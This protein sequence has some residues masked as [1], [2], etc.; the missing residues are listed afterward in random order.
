[1]RID[2][3]DGVTR[4]GR[5]E[6]TGPGP[7]ER[8]EG[9]ERPGDR[10]ELSDRAREVAAL[11]A[12]SGALADVRR[13]KVEAIRASLDD[14]TFRVDPRRLAQKILEFEDGLER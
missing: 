9:P 10:V 14:G 3:F 6:A 13:E 11:A 1:M 2:G 4:T 12:R 8:S 7:V 5:P